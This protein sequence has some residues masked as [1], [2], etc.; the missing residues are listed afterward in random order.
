MVTQSKRASS[1]VAGVCAIGLAL[2]LKA[3][4]SRAGAT[5]LLWIL[6]PSAWLARFVGGIDL[7]YEQGAGFIS[8]THRMVVGPACAG[9]NFLIICFLCLYFSFERHFSS[10]LRWLVHSLL[11]SFGAA[12]AANSLRI[13]L[14]AHLWD[15]DIYG[16]WLSPELAHRLAG[17]AIYYGSLLALYYAIQARLGARAP[18]TAPLFWYVSVSLGVPLA[19]RMFTDNGSQFA[20]H[21]A[22]VIVVALLLT[23]V[24]FLPS[25]LGH[26][27]HLEP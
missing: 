3:F 17:T 9:V 12:V 7:V 11:A 26:R 24:K 8:H 1:V 23:G 10:K 13:F 18:S 19:G 27:V 21:A 6:A 20:V 14:S 15:A 22:S 5:E 25:L 2:G 4:Y 16:P